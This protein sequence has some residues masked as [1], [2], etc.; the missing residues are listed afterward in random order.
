MGARRSLTVSYFLC[1]FAATLFYLGVAIHIEGITGSALITNMAFAAPL[2]LP[3]LTAPVI[4]AVVVHHSC[5]TVFWG[6]LSAM[7][8]LYIIA[9]GLVQLTPGIAIALTVCVGWVDGFIRVGRLIAAK[10]ISNGESSGSGLLP[11]TFFIQFLA[12]GMAGIVMTILPRPMQLSQLLLAC[13][14]CAS[15]A[16]IT[17]KGL[18]SDKPKFAGNNVQPG[19]VIPA[20]LMAPFWRL[21]VFASL[22]QGTFNA[23]RVVLPAM[24]MEQYTSAVGIFQIGVSTGA[25]AGA[26]LLMRIGVSS[27]VRHERWFTLM[28]A[29][30][31]LV[32]VTSSSLWCSLPAYMLFILFFEVVF[33][34]RQTALNELSSAIEIPAL[35]SYQYSLGYL[36]V[37]VVTLLSSWLIDKW[38]LLAACTLCSMAALVSMLMVRSQVEADFLAATGLSR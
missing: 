36:G 9:A 18:P 31:A 6:A 21:I 13:T 1:V 7:L 2:L 19:T 30:A 5:R 23:T 29:V 24:H 10:L 20:R 22:A 37:F 35:A 12:S 32:A 14:I 8:L 38:S 26:A 17:A 3:V 33:I 4:R 11:Q 28:M 15:L 34:A 16:L 27:A 25:I